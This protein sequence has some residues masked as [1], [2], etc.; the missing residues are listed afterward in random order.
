VLLTAGALVAMWVKYPRDEEKFLLYV[1]KSIWDEANNKWVFKDADDAFLLAEGDKA[2][3]WLGDESFALWRG[4]A[5]WSNQARL[6]QYLDESAVVGS[7][8]SFG[9]GVPDRKREAVA[10]RAWLYLCGSSMELRETH[11]PFN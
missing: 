10:T 5:E 4:G 2:C 1:H 3:D 6:T 9:G 11:N 7:E 8:W